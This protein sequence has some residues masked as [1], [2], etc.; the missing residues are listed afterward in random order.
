MS[1]SATEIPDWAAI[2]TLEG[3]DYGITLILRR[4]SMNMAEREDRAMQDIK[5][6]SDAKSASN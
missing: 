3:M 5:M 1:K 6:Q 4:E 2:D